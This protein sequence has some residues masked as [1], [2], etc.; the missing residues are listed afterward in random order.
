[1]N[2]EILFI[3]AQLQ[4]AYGGEPWFGRNLRELLEEIP[5]DVVTLKK[6]GSHSLLE[7]LWHMVT[8]REFTIS[9]LQ[10]NKATAL[11]WFEENDWRRL[12]ATDPGFWRKGLDAL[13]AAQVTLLQ[14]IGAQDDSLL[15]RMVQGRQYNF[16]K[17]LHGIIQHDIY[18]IGQIA[19]AHK[20]HRG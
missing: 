16:R 9:M 15:D 8:W 6:E 3:A 17:L 18:H 7:I 1:M 5:E 11:Q 19:Y 2:S 20:W 4:D 14:L 10:E 13:Q 12:D